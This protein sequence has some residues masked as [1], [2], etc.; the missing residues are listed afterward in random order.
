MKKIFSI[1]LILALVIKAHALTPFFVQLFQSDGAINQSQIG[2]SVWPPTDSPFVTYG[3]NLVYNG[4]IETIVLNGSG[5]GTNSLFPGTYRF[6]IT[7][8][9]AAFVAVIPD[10]LVTNSIAL[11]VT[12]LPGFSGVGLNSYGVITNQLGFA[13]ATNSF[14]GMTNAL[15]YMPATNSNSG[16]VFALGFTPATNNYNGITNALGYIPA[17]AANTND[18]AR[19]T[20]AGVTNA[21]GYIPANAANTNDFVR[22]TPAGIIGALGYTPPTNG[23]IGSTN[24]PT[25]ASLATNGQIVWVTYPT[26]GLPGSAFTNLPVGSLMS[27]TN[28]GFYV[29]SNLTW[30]VH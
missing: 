1:F 14:K 19:A 27:T 6:Y 4:N 20:P 13:P 16:I 17:N 26:N 23:Y 5:Y 3:T 15:G 11:Y 28:G 12:N 7:N 18:F 10:T 9:N 25:H 8:L 30:N 29:L 24:L 21:L 22:A 2:V